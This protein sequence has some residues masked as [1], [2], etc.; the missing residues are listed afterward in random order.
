MTLSSPMPASFAAAAA[1]LMGLLEKISFTTIPP[2]KL[3]SMSVWCDS[4]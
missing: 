3:F 4:V 1:K 2:L